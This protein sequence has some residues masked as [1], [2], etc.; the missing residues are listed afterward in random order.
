MNTKPWLKSDG[1]PKSENELQMECK[2]WSSSTWDEYL[3]Q[4]EHQQKEI[5]MDKPQDCETYSQ[6]EHTNWFDN[7][8]D[9]ETYS[10]LESKLEDE[11]K[12]LSVEQQRVLRSI[13][14]EN[15]S[16]GQAAKELKLNKSTVMRN[17]DRALQSL[18][19]ALI[20]S[21]LKI[22]QDS[23]SQPNELAG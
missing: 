3:A 1:T 4:L 17:R 23:T 12:K 21:V 11:L 19:K 6:D 16:L 2:S 20:L 5:L 9:T 14:W 10:H 13:F 18:S 15:L 7:L 8:F 22:K